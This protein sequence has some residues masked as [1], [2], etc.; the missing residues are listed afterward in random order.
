MASYDRAVGKKKIFLIRAEPF[1]EVQPF[2]FEATCRWVRVREKE[3]TYY[4]AGFEITEISDE[5]RSQLRKLI[6]LL[7]KPP[8]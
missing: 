6:D 7:L 2:T 5:A 3:R 1:D 8:A 4:L